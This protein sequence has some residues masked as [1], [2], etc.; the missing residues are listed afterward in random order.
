MRLALLG[1]DDPRQPLAVFQNQAGEVAQQLAAGGRRH[2]FPGGLRRTCR[3]KGS[4]G[5]VSAA[6]RHRGDDLLG[7]R[8]LDVDPLLDGRLHPLAADEVLVALDAP[9]EFLHCRHVKSRSV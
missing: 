4:V 9:H 1:H 8:V 7:R 5:V 6:I 2:R 3:D